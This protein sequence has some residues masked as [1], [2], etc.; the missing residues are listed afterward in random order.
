MANMKCN[1]AYAFC[2]YQVKFTYLVIL[3]TDLFVNNFDPCDPF[4]VH[5]NQTAMSNLANKTL[6]SNFLNDVSYIF[7]F[8]FYICTDD[9]CNPKTFC[10][11]LFY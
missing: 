6:K 9:G 7:C 11:F 8:H 2:Q 5:N 4:N 10:F 1:P 3:L